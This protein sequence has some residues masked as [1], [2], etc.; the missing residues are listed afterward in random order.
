M[1]KFKIL[2]SS[3]RAR[4]GELQ[5]HHGIVQTPVFMPVG[6]KGTVKAMLP[7]ELAEIGFEIILGN[8]YHLHLRPG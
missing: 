1:K 2:K 8:T 3:S 5:T 4:R 7:Q 6:T